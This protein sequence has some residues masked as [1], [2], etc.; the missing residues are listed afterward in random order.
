MAQRPNISALGADHVQQGIPVL[1][2]GY[3]QLGNGHRAGFPLHFSAFPGDFI[4]LFALYLDGGIHG[5]NLL[6]LPSESGQ[7]SLQFLPAH[8]TV[9]LLQN[10]SRHVLGVRHH[11]QPQPGMV[12]LFMGL[13]ELHRP[14]CPT[15]EHHQQTGGH[16]VQ[17]SG[18]ADAPL[19]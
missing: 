4:E 9:A 13:S 8:R 14:G 11:A 5:G 16:G 18:M 17:G 12:F 3:F 7:H 15:D 2:S 1:F 6:N 19:P 10:R